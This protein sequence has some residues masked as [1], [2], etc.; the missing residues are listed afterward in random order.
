MLYAY[1]RG[2]RIQVPPVRPNVDGPMFKA[3]TVE[4]D[5][6]I[7]EFDHLVDVVDRTPKTV[8]DSMKRRH[9]HQGGAGITA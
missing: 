6:L 2:V 5:R 4:G 1:E 3:Y 9:R 8:P 7:V